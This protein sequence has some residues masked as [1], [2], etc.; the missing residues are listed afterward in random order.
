EYF[1]YYDSTGFANILSADGETERKDESVFEVVDLE[2]IVVLPKL[3][4]F[5]G[6]N[7]K[8]LKTNKMFYYDIRY[9]DIMRNFEVTHLQFSGEDHTEE[10]AVH[11]ILPNNDGQSFRIRS[12]GS[13]KLWRLYRSRMGPEK[14]W[15]IA[16]GPLDVWNPFLT[17]SAT[18]LP[19]DFVAL[20]CQGNGFLCKPLDEGWR[21]KS[22]LAA[23][24]DNIVDESCHLAVEE[25]VVSRRI[26]EIKFYTGDARVVGRKNTLKEVRTFENT[27]EGTNWDE[28]WENDEKVWTNTWKRTTTSTKSSKVEVG[29]DI[30]E[31]PYV[32]AGV[33]VEM[34]EELTDTVTWGKTNIHRKQ[35][36]HKATCTVLPK[37]RV[38]VYDDISE[39]TWEVPFSYK[40]SDLLRTGYTD[41]YYKDDGLYTYTITTSK[42][43]TVSEKL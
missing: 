2:L 31:I 7:G 25:P 43:R 32:D 10:A 15:I 21:K 33:H 14:P 41:T 18:K 27:T 22:C 42:T 40:V 16:D 28:Y 4:V 13:N 35:A 9:V 29:F 23:E 3:V 20:R 36:G 19:G 30:T 11:E 39:D 26:S 1:T 17:F 24:I 6:N 38:K 34:F 5:K 8:Y 12:L 37:T